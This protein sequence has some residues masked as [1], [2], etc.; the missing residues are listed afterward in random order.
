MVIEDYKAE[1]H[2]LTDTQ[3]DAEIVAKYCEQHLFTDEKAIQRLLDTDPNLFSRI[4][5]WIEDMIVKFKGTKE[6]RFLLEAQGLYEK[7]LSTRGETTGAGIEQHSIVNIP[8]KGQGVYLD[9]DLYNGLSDAERK[10]MLKA[11]VKELGG[12]TFTAFDK[13]GNAV[14]FKIVTDKRFVNSNGK[15]VRANNDLARKNN[16][17]KVKQEAVDLIDELV[18]TSKQGK[19]EPA[20]HPHDWIDNNGQNNWEKWTTNIV[21]KNNTVWEAML[22]IATSTNGEKILYDIDPIKMVGQAG[23]SATSSPNKNVPQTKP[24]VNGQHSIGR[25]FDEMAGEAKAEHGVSETVSAK[26]LIKKHR[27][28]CFFII[29]HT[30][31]CKFRNRSLFLQEVP[32]VFRFQQFRRC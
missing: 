13:N 12:Q 4:K 10:E 22:N 18:L 30:G 5:Y 29:L 1:G 15:T 27:K 24:V 8:G 9:T 23:K 11:R 14:D 16:S 25:G 31:C 28:R 6:E 2:E 32:H 21:D 3:A 17:F 19:P 26:I 20:K 7:A